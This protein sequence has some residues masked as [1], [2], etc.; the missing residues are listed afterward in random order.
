MVLRCP[1]L[2]VF[3]LSQNFHDIFTIKRIAL[4]SSSGEAD[5]LQVFQVKGDKKK[6]TVGGC[7]CMKG[8]LHRD[9]KFKVIRE[10]EVIYKGTTTVQPVLSKHLRDNQNLLA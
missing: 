9:K 10:G 1:E 6:V 7:R 2:T 8:R 4:F 5:V 3:S